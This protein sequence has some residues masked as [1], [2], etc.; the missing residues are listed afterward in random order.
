MVKGLENLPCE[1]KV[2]VFPQRRLG[3]TSSQCSSTE[4]TAPKETE[5]TFSGGENKGQHVQVAIY[6][7]KKEIFYCDNSQLLEQCPQ[8]CGRLPMGG[9]FQ[10]SA[11]C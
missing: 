1:G 7:R 11:V 9:G 4:R 8:G 3:G 6:V 10:D 5:A 2:K